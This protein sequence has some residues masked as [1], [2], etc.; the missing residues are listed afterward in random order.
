MVFY[1]HGLPP[2]PMLHPLS[3]SARLLL[4]G[5]MGKDK[6]WLS[7][8]LTEEINHSA[9]QRIAFQSASWEL[10]YPAPA[11]H[12]HADRHWLGQHSGAR[13]PTSVTS[14]GV[15]D[16]SQHRGE[17]T[18]REETRRK[19][20]VD[21]KIGRFRRGSGKFSQYYTNAGMVFMSMLPPNWFLLMSANS[22]Q[23]SGQYRQCKFRYGV[24]SFWGGQ[25]NH[26]S[27]FLFVCFAHVI[28]PHALSLTP[29]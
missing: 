16:Q 21:V 14:R 1:K 25:E 20:R 18:R 23:N 10:H 19:G 17:E 13:S 15:S 3:G 9:H 7:W 22:L 28:L 26:N 5:T 12:Y 11:T 24:V 8:L 27:F 4:P 6:S 29:K 2:P